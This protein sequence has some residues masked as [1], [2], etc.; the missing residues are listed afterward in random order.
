VSRAFR[1]PAKGAELDRYLAFWESIRA[2]YETYEDSVQEVLIAVLCSPEF[3]FLCEPTDEL[4]DGR[5][6]PEWMLANR[7]SYF[8]WNSPPDEELRDL[9]R[10]GELRDDL[11]QQVDRMVAD[12]RSSRFLR[13][14]TYEWLR[15]DRHEGMT[16]NVGKHP[17]YTRFV[18]R[19]MA[20]ETYAFVEH[21]VRNDLPLSTFV[22]ADF[23]MLNQNLAEFYGVSGVRGQHFRAVAMP[24]EHAERRAGLMSHGS[25]YVGHSD[26]TEPH[27]IK[28]AVW[29]K[30]RLLG[31][32]PPPPPPNV[33]DLDPETPGFDKMTLKQ[34]IESHRDK[35]SCRDCHAGLDP[36]GFVFERMSAV[37]RLQP[38]RKG[39]IIDATSTLPDGTE[40]DGLDGIRAWLV[41]QQ[42]G[43]FARSVLE[44]A[45]SYALGRELHFADTEEIEAMLA[46]VRGNG[47]RARAAL[48]AV[49][50]SPSFLS[51]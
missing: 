45:F 35:A 42:Q 23:A 37:G 13:R 46:Y 33:P 27:P 34:Q 20:E 29:L 16:I 36:Y 32:V 6:L 22:A 40:V 51:K 2:D 11:D 48:K 12:P 43:E 19:D 15:M 7:I 9:A 14:F 8:L 50:K 1:R 4:V 49:V 21:V 30:A 18:K 17:D 5:D 38:K 44:H 41:A 25:F 24:A 28:R 26:G 3:L 31:D 10:R 39:K 47:Y